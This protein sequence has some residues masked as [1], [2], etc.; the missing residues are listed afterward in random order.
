[1]ATEERRPLSGRRGA[2]SRP[3]RSSS[4]PT[5]SPLLPRRA[6][7]GEQPRAPGCGG[8]PG[9]RPP[10]PSA[11]RVRWA[12]GTAAVTPSVGGDDTG[13]EPSRPQARSSTIHLFTI[14]DRRSDGTCEER[15]AS[16]PSGRAGPRARRASRV[17]SYIRLGSRSRCLPLGRGAV[18]EAGSGSAPDERR[19]DRVV[20]IG[21]GG[22]VLAGEG[23]AF[24]R[25]VGQLKSRGRPGLF[26]YLHR[27]PTRG[28]AGLHSQTLPSPARVAVNALQ[29]RRSPTQGPPFPDARERV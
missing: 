4:C 25:L 29:A 28:P 16:P 7:R 21:G 26:L 3:S 19:V 15:F 6:R 13:S 24:A 5:R 20:T 1:M 10:H 2:A 14:G 18:N 27:V 12:G 8:R 17:S 22:A 23:E 9:R 11:S